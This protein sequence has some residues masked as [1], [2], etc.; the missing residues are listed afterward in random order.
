[1]SPGLG[2]KPFTL[3]SDSPLG[4]KLT[5]QLCI[6]LLAEQTFQPCALERRATARHRGG[7]LHP[8][9]S[10]SDVFPAAVHLSAAN[11]HSAPWFGAK[12]I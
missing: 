1:M 11:F 9:L 8:G 12:Q 2:F 7:A 10:H 4:L 5:A 3:Q 6:L